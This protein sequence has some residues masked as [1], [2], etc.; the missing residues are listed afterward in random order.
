VSE[1][2]REPVPQ[3]DRYDR[4]RYDRA[5][6]ALTGLALGDALGPS[7]RRALQLLAQGAPTDVTGRWGDTNGAAMRVAPVGIAYPPG[8]IDRLVVEAAR[9]ANAAAAL[10]ARRVGDGSEARR[11]RPTV[12]E[13]GRLALVSTKIPAQSAKVHRELLGL[14]AQLPFFGTTLSCRPR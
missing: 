6:G 1:R 5:L 12:G 4:D 9:I 10:A 8:P 7:T 2:A 14:S 11:A 3:R 13:L